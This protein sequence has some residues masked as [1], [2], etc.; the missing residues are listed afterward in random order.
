[1]VSDLINELL[2]NK[3]KESE[4]PYVDSAPTRQTPTKVIVFVIGGITFSEARFVQRI[5]HSKPE[6]LVLLGG[7]AL[8][9]SKDFYFKYL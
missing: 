4:F 8:L 6:N 9:N 2:K 7:S 1:M 5:N 3:L